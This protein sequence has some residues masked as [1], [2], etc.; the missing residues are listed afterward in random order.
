[1][2]GQ[3]ME[4][5]VS[6]HTVRYQPRAR[7]L[8]PPKSIK[9]GRLGVTVD[10]PNENAVN[11]F[12][13]ADI[14]NK[15]KDHMLTPNLSFNTQLKR[16]IYIPNIPTEI[17]NKADTLITLEIETAIKITLKKLEKF[18]PQK[19]KRNTIKLIIDSESSKDKIA[20]KGSITLFNKQ[21]PAYAKVPKRT[22]IL[23][24][25]DNPAR[26]HISTQA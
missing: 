20:T 26:N 8:D 6:M 12:L 1:M 13:D 19:T 22:Q 2:Y 18:N 7:P 3:N 14:I 5:A 9:E 4:K 17:F 11:K 25:G 10:Y 23:T 15:L 24:S 16:E 21:L